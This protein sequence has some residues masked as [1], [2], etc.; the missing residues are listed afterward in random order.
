MQRIAIAASFPLG[1]FEDP[2]EGR[3]TNPAATWLPQLAMAFAEHR[4]FEI[5]WCVVGCD[6]RQP[7]TWEKWGQ[8]FHRIPAPGMSECM[9]LGRWPQ[10]RGFSALLA[11]LRPRLL[12]CWGSENL[13]GA[14]LAVFHGP[15]ILSMQGIITA[16]F[17]TGDLTGWRWR[18]FRHW[19]ARALRRAALVTCESRWG[20]DRVLEIVPDKPVRQVE[21][22]VHPSFYTVQ[23]NPRS[24]RP[25]VL[26]AG[27][28]SRLK[29]VD[30]LVEMLRRHPRRSWRLVLAGGG[31]LADSLSAL[32]D[33]GVELAGTLS[34]SQLQARMA[35]AWVL[36]H[37]SRADTSPNVVKEARVIGLPVVGS[38][39]GGHAAYIEHGRDGFLMDSEDPDQ[40]FAA[41]D[42]L[43]ANLARC[44]EMGAVNHQQFRDHFRPERTA[45]A[46]LD[47][48]REMAA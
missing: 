5:H 22:G 26:F 8:T 46:F 21:Y 7:A 44:R 10:R 39:H 12:H 47:L 35:A 28:L 41:L 6:T 48:Y 17:K 32:R 15:S 3:S 9:L 37:P 36:V 23:W 40:W 1:V 30:I 38:P 34:T 43:C 29:G 19:E 16:Y 33:P 13:N 4:E 25:E 11:R 18:L 42:Q 31:G 45:A 2:L 14:A 24:E 20:L 27:S